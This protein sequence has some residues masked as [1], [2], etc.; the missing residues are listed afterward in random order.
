MKAKFHDVLIFFKQTHSNTYKLTLPLYSSRNSIAYVFEYTKTSKILILF[1]KL[2][3]KKCSF[4]ISKYVLLFQC[5]KIIFGVQYTRTYE[6]FEKNL[7][8]DEAILIKQEYLLLYY[9][10]YTYHIHRQTY[11][12]ALIGAQCPDGIR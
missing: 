11:S 6:I 7:E 2:T 8:R 10:F 3:K 9:E 4:Q 12:T 1:K 5:S